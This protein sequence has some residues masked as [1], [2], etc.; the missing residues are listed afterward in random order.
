M[1]CPTCKTKIDHGLDLCPECGQA[2][3]PECGAALDDNV[4]FVLAAVRSLSWPVH[5]VAR[6]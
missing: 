2:L 5:A 4:P 1:Y 3:C 6:P